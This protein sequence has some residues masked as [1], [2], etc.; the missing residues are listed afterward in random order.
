MKTLLLILLLVPMMSFGQD[1]D[2]MIFKRGKIAETSNC[3]INYSNPNST[4]NK[5]VIGFDIIPLGETEKITVAKSSFKRYDFSDPVK[6]AGLLI[7]RSAN[8]KIKAIAYM[9]AGGLTTAL[10]SEDKTDD[11]NN[12]IYVVGGSFGVASLYNGIKSLILY[13]KAGIKLVGHNGAGEKLKL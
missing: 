1:Y 13:K 9:L 12:L 11:V 2:L 6:S 7:Q 5:T 3:T 8:A 10:L 4:G